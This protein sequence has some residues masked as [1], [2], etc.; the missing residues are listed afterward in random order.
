[1][2][3]IALEIL[4]GGWNL[5]K[6]GFA[7]LGAFLSKLNAQGVAG[8]VVALVLAILCFREWSEAR[9]WHKQSD[10]F[11]QL[12]NGEKTAFAKTVA[13]YRSAAARQKADEDA[14][15]AHT[16]QQQQAANQ[17]TDNEYQARLAA[18]RAEYERLP[19]S[20]SSHSGSVAG[21][22]VPGVSAPTRGPDEAA[23]KDG[24]PSSDAL[25]ATEQAIQLDELEKWIERQHV[26]D[27][28]AKP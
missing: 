25:I 17:E 20:S 28:N 26:I 1:M 12:Y 2:G 8:L 3:A 22:S 23:G 11:E 7:A 24:L 18:A 27:P 16:V 13:D 21:A 14:K 9:H 19:R 10:R 6:M 5:A 15:N 4:T